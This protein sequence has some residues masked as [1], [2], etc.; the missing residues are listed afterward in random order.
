MAFSREEIEAFIAE[1]Q[2]DPQLRDRVRNA[3]LADD[4]LAL[5]GIVARLGERVEQLGERL[6]QLGERV[7]ALS[8]QIAGLT[9]Q[10]FQLTLGQNQLTGKVTNIDGRLYE[11]E[12]ERKIGPWIG[13]RFRRARVLSL[14]DIEAFDEA[15]RAGGLTREEAD[16]ANELDLVVQAEDRGGPT[17]EAVLAFEVSVTVDASDVVRAARRADLLRRV[18]INA[19]AAVAG[20]QLT[21][22][23]AESLLD[24]DV[25]SFVRKKTPAA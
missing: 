9:S 20:D 8:L 19:F 13:P 1:L 3:I 7:D 6:D 12:F 15:V 23:A 21:R 4:F 14:Y 22:E 2:Q 16:D 18:G 5:P 24:R 11:F 25:L 17:S 10:V